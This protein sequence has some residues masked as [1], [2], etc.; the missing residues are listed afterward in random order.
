MI[1]ITITRQDSPS[2]PP[3][4]PLP[5]QHLPRSPLPLGNTCARSAVLIITSISPKTLTAS[6]D[7]KH[8]HLFAVVI[9]FVGLNQAPVSHTPAA[10]LSSPARK[11]AQRAAR[12]LLFCFFSPSTPTPPLFFPARRVYNQRVVSNLLPPFFNFPFPFSHSNHRY[13][14]GACFLAGSG[15]VC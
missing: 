12:R 7:V 1:I 6:G 3:P 2:S 13:Q 11:K 14:S 10:C 4:T 15:G 5:T 8:I 9:S